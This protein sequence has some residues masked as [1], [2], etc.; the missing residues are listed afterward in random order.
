MTAATGFIGRRGPWLNILLGAILVLA[1]AGIGTSVGTPVGYA[2]IGPV[3]WVAAYALGSTVWTGVAA[4]FSLSTVAFGTDDPTLLGLTASLVL[5]AIVQLDR[6]VSMRRGAQADSR[7]QRS[8]IAMLALVFF[9]SF[10]LIGI[11]Q[12]VSAVDTASYQLPLGLTIAAAVIAAV[13]RVLDRADDTS[14]AQAFR[15]GSRH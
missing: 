12:L 11:V 8:G 7:V 4:V 2:V 1:S 6:S 10:F 15:P 13:A 3:A 9:V 5:L 14:N